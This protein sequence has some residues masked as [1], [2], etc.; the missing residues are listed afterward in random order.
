MPIDTWVLI[1]RAAAAVIV[2]GIASHTIGHI[3]YYND[4]TILHS[5]FDSTETCVTAS[6][7][8]VGVAALVRIAKA[9]NGFHICR[10]P[11]GRCRPRAAGMLLFVCMF[12]E[13]SLCGLFHKEPHRVP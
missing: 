5:M 10:D 9:A 13:S 7:T 2:L 12:L 4:Y 11:H 3:I 1:V 8:P 6:T